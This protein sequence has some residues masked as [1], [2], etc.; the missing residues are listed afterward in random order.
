MSFEKY[1]KLQKKTKRNFPKTASSPEAWSERIQIHSSASGPEQIP[2]PA[3]NRKSNET[4]KQFSKL[5]KKNLRDC[6]IC[7]IDVSLF[8]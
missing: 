2:K 6:R 1:Q 8:P 4:F 7:A 3:K 5:H